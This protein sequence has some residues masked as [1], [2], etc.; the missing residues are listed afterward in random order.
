MSPAKFVGIGLV[1]LTTG[2]KA[3][4]GASFEVGQHASLPEAPNVRYNGITEI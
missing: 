1:W 4:L 3:V 2:V